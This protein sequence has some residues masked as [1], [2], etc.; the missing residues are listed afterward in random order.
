M[1]VAW[2]D[3]ERDVRVEAPAGA[4]LSAVLAELAR[5]VGA[6]GDLPVWCGTDLLAADTPLADPRLRRGARLRF[7]TA[8]R[9]ADRSAVLA[10]QVVGGPAAGLVVPLERGR[11]TIGRA[12]DNDLVLPDVDVSR[13]HAVVTVTATDIDVR[14]MGSANGSW[15]AGERVPADGAAL[16]AGDIVR[17]GSSLLAIAGPVGAPASVRPGPDGTVLLDRARRAREPASHRV[18]TVPGDVSHPRPRRV[19]W[20]T[21]LLPAAAGAAIAWVFGQPEFLLFALLSPAMLIS[22][23]VGDQLHWRRT[24]RRRAATMRRRRAEIDREVVRQLRTEA[25]A[26]RRAAPDPAEL[27]RAVALPDLR[28]WARRHSDPD[29]LQVRL[30]A[31]ELPS[32][33]ALRNGTSVGPAGTVVDV[34]LCVDLRQGPIGIAG[35]TATRRAAAWW[36]VG[37]LAAHTA[38]A[39]LEF[40]LLLGPESEAQWRWTRWLPHLRGK[41]AVTADECAAL[42]DAITSIADQRAAA[43]LSTNAS[44]LVVVVDRPASMTGLA[45]VS[46]V[47]ARG[48]DVGVTAVWLAPSAGALPACCASTARVDAVTGTRIA[49]RDPDGTEHTAVLDQVSPEWADHLAR[50]LAPLVADGAAG[51]AALP[52]S[53]GLLDVLDLRHPSAA[54]VAERWDR[55][56]GGA[57]SVIGVTATGTLPV[58]LTTDG[59]HALVAGTTGAGKSELLRTVVAGLAT[60]HPPDELNLLLIDY[61]GGAAFAECARLPHVAGLVTDLDPYLTE[62]A[63]RSLRAELRRRERLFAAAG[64]TDLP[65]YR[66]SDPAE[67]L[68]RLVI[69]VDE[70]ATLADELPGFV[71]GL[72]SVARLG[73]SLG[74]HLILATQR[75]SG[76]V[77]PEIR[78]N[79]DLRIALRVADPGESRDVI[80]SPLA[81]SIER[82]FPGR[83]Y[84]RSGSE[85]VCFQAGYGS[86]TGDGERQRM[87]V[88]LLDEWRR[89]P[90]RIQ[91]SGESDLARLVHAA[92]AAARVRGSAEPQPPWQPPLPEVL[93]RAELGPPARRGAIPLGRVDLPDEQ[94]Q[95]PLEF[96]LASGASL[97]I[98]GA[99]RTGRTTALAG[100]GLAAATTFSPAELQVQVIDAGGELARRLG[101]LP[102]CASVLGPAELALVPRLLA[103]LEREAAGR[104]VDPT[105]ITESVPTAL[106]LIDGWD[107]VCA[108][109]GEPVAAATA[110]T[111]TTLLRAA[112]TAGFAI[113]VTGGRALLA[114]RL[115]GG[116]GERLV[117]RLGDRHDTGISGIRPHDSLRLPPGRAARGTDGAFVQL[118]LPA[119]STTAARAEVAA[120]ARRWT[121]TGPIPATIRVRPLPDQVLLA[122]L[123]AGPGRFALGLA[124]DDPA[125]LLVD[126][127][128]SP[129]RWLVAGPPRSGRTTL[130]RLLAAQAHTAGIATLIA[131]T[132]QSALLAD[133]RS[134]GIPFIGPA[135]SAGR[136]P[137]GRTLVL[138]DDSESFAATAAGEQ[139][140]EW[141][142]DRELP[143]ALVVAA[144]A[145]DLVTSYRGVAAEVRRHRYG[146]LLR[147]G[148]LDGE[149]FGVRLPR[150]GGPAPPGRGFAVAD[151]SWGPAFADDE[152]VPLQVAT[153]GQAQP[154]GPP[155]CG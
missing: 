66:R 106:V 99:A 130:L 64:A 61:K 58:D 105:A 133:A 38:P 69:V 24:R 109:L 67:P 114:S 92:R 45:G 35:P 113:A 120:V 56:T 5:A 82:R 107:A 93:S 57:T 78:T 65:G 23:A 22:S 127:F 147:P 84:L 19:Q 16:R 30:G 143:V 135:S 33:L 7:G 77:S 111:L 31:A 26:R 119:D 52:G 154:S 137:A 140:V 102:H 118:A 100:L 126:P 14:D 62:R 28:V 39:D 149:L 110:D 131:A 123:P 139:L 17:M 86:A 153:P 81:A 117:L 112:P 32:A 6:P 121:S 116:F 12:A 115:A 79:T 44:W 46:D 91:T 13:H 144:R 128:A 146:V 136:A 141:A 145:D 68:P 122:E 18:I 21:A 63:L 152:P 150:P 1:T 10:L 41:V 59:P 37:Q 2:A 95:S 98:V 104:L 88:E 4:R 85:V 9:A 151:P 94:R 72:V 124:G 76:A 40:A 138:V 48:P 129:A 27:R 50:D 96:D 53:C 8:D 90:S 42:L 89:A 11:L 134:N 74:L 142:R 83:G 43:R 49:V 29:L 3:R 80:G 71:S 20:V 34:P 70:F 108:A 15:L 148:P 55:S 47:L 54:V 87:G 60:A 73:R 97:L 25:A 101:P 155:M 103:R 36:V 51:A 132:E 125:P 75:P